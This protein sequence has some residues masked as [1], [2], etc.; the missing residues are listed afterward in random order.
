LITPPIFHRVSVPPTSKLWHIILVPIS[1]HNGTGKVF[2]SVVP[3]LPH[4]PRSS[5]TRMIDEISATK[6]ARHLPSS[7]P[8]LRH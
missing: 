2:G 6:K 1:S 3:P 5:N 8:S 7:S 4:L